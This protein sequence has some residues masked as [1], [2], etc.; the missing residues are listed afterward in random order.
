V[1]PWH[2]WTCL[3]TDGSRR[4]TVRC[5]V[6]FPVGSSALQDGLIHISWLDWFTFLFFLHCSSPS[7]PC[8]WF[9]HSFFLLDVRT[10][11]FSF[12]DFLCCSWRWILPFS[13]FIHSFGWVWFI[14]TTTSLRSGRTT[15]CAFLPLVHG[16]VH[17]FPFWFRFSSISFLTFLPGPSTFPSFWISTAWLVLWTDVWYFVL[18]TFVHSICLRF[19]GFYHR[20]IPFLRFCISGSTPFSGWFVFRSDCFVAGWFR[21]GLSQQTPALA[22]CASNLRVYANQ[23]G[24]NEQRVLNN[25]VQT[26]PR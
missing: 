5:I 4:W 20:S 23:R 7:D 10:F 9:L 17:S 15:G 19:H 16:C 21:F 22:R 13:H 8:G 14:Y 26:L 11:P 12:L 3:D 25:F 24:W 2:S 6:H 18:V 1:D